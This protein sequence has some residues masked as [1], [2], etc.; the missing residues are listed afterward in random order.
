MSTLGKIYIVRIINKQS[1]PMVG[2]ICPNGKPGT[3]CRDLENR[4]FHPHTQV[5]IDAKTYNIIDKECI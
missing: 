1:D 4:T 2:I 5:L 3:M